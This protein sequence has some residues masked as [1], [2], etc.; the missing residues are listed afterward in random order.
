MVFIW[1][2]LNSRNDNHEGLSFTERIIVIVHVERFATDWVHTTI[3]ALFTIAGATMALDK[4]EELFQLAGR[5]LVQGLEL[6]AHEDCPGSLE[7]RAG[8]SQ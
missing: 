2:L 8:R 1:R 6:I 7:S 3:G 5:L 4:A